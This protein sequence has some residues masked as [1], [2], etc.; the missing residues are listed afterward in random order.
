MK[1]RQCLTWGWGLLGVGLSNT[2]LA[3]AWAADRAAAAGKLAW[4]ERALLGFGT[5]LWIKAAH[6]NTDLLES[7]MNAA[8]K[9]IRQVEIGRAHV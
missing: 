7:A 8:I 1:R 2:L 9:A 4:R 3:Q 5:T 6:D